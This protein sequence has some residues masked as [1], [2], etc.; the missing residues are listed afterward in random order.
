MSEAAVHYNSESMT[1]FKKGIDGLIET[2]TSSEADKGKMESDPVVRN[3]FGGGD[4]AWSEAAGVYTS[5]NTV[6]TQL[7]ELSGLLRDCLEGLGIAVVASKDGFEQMDDDVKQQMINIHQ[8][9]DEAKTKADREAGR[10]APDD[11]AGQT[12]GGDDSLQ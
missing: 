1:E 5:Y 12:A 7:T 4:G 8:R 6:L 2:L 10:I 9:T 3:Q 11:G